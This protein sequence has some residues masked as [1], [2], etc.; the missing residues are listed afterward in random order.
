M[1]KAR[2]LKKIY[3]AVDK[4]VDLK[5]EGYGCDKVA[6]ILELLNSLSVEIENS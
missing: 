5:D 2:A 4:M 6:R 3:I 1:N